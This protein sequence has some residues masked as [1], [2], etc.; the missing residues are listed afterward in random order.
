MACN[1]LIQSIVARDLNNV[2]GHG[3][4]ELAYINKDDMK[5]FRTVTKNAVCIM[6]SKTFESLPGLLKGREH[7]VLTSQSK[8]QYM[9]TSKFDKE[10]LELTGV[11]IVNNVSQAMIAAQLIA[12]MEH[13]PIFV[14]GG[15]TV[16]RQFMEH[17]DVWHV[18]TNLTS[19][20]FNKPVYFHES[21]DSNINYKLIAET[22]H[23][24]CDIPHS[25]KI[26]QK[27]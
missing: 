12:Q 14:I 7:I 25:I 4:N 16:Y 24:D 6:G 15:G 13:R 2:I 26:Y 18:T 10:V 11:E 17:I 22:T 3:D 21:F 9:K 19:K 27:L 1:P 20:P 5:Y 8:E 23:V